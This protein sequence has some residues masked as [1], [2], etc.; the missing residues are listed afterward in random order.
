MPEGNYKKASIRVEVDEPQ[1]VAAVRRWLDKWGDSLPHL[2]QYGCGCHLL[3]YDVL[4][5]AEALDELPAAVRAESE[6][7]LGAGE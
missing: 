2:K 7:T 4:A 1:E 5:P 6:W 3:L